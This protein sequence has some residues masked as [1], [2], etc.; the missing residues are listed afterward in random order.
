MLDYSRIGRMDWRG[1]RV[2]GRRD[3]LSPP[4]RPSGSGGTAQARPSPVW[5]CTLLYMLSQ[6]REIGRSFSG[7]QARYGTLSIAS[8]IIVLGILV[9]INWI[10]Q[11]PEQALGP[12]RKRPVFTLSEQTRKVLQTLPNPVNIKVFTKGEDFDRHPDKL[13]EFQYGSKR[14]NVEYIDVYKRPAVAEHDQIQ[15]EG[16]V[17]FET[18]GPHRARDERHRTGSGERAHQGR[19]GQGKDRVPRPRARRDGHNRKRSPDRVHRD[20]TGAQDRPLQGR[21]ARAAPAERRSGGSDGRRRCPA[22]WS[23]TRRARST[24]SAPP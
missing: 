23:T 3:P 15:Q 20:D 10:A 17:V 12:H 1:A 22:R 21:V 8:V 7:R 18:G 6:W 13:D 2:R 19:A 9:G 14:V 11:P 16:T 24:W 5:F 4:R